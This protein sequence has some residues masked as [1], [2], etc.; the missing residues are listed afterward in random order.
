LFA[1][2]LSHTNDRTRQAKADEVLSKHADGV[3][4]ADHLVTQRQLLDTTGLNVQDLQILLTYMH[5]NGKAALFE[6][7]RGE[8][9]VVVWPR[10][11]SLRVHV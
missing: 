9:V 10:P 4:A 11:C 8:K 2:S 1:L 6:T 5:A 7:A 3:F